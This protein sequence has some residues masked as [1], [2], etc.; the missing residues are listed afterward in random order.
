[1]TEAPRARHDP[2]RTPAAALLFGFTGAVPFLVLTGII[3]VAGSSTWLENAF[4]FYSAL[5]LSF[6]G[7]IR[8]GDAGTTKDPGHR[9]LTLSILPSLLAW[10][11]LMLDDFYLQLAVLMLGHLLTAVVDGLIP[12]KA[13]LPWLRRLRLQLSGLVLISHAILLT[14]LL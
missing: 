14:L 12:P 11:A 7:G 8:W 5:I 3:A 10:A 13:Q 6:L 9:D 4:T 2:I 1:M